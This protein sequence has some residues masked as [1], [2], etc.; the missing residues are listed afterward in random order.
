MCKRLLC[1]TILVWYFPKKFLKIHRKTPVL[2]VAGLKLATILKKRLWNKCFRMGF[3]EI[4]KNTF[5][6]KTPPMAGSDFFM[7]TEWKADSKL[8]ET[9]KLLPNILNAQKPL[10]FPEKKSILLACCGSE[11]AYEVRFIHRL[12]HHIHRLRQVYW[13][14]YKWNMNIPFAEKIEVIPQ[15]K[16]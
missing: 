2:E 8:Y 10:T 1:E 9:N 7:P 14:A 5:F 16:E 11:Y 13:A 6:Y 15:G 12:I 3:E 4:F